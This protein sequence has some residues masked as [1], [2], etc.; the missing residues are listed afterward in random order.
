MFSPE[1]RQRATGL[2][3]FNPK[4]PFETKLFINGE[5]VDSKLGKT[6][7]TV[8]PATEEI[9]THVQEA[10]TQDVDIAVAAAKAAFE[11]GSEWR[12]LPGSGRRDLL[13]KLAQAIEDNSEYLSKLESLDNVKPWKNAAYSA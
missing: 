2:G 13:L 3:A 11:D 1:K 6:F 10:S 8:D 7:P 5:F 4:G 12:Q 9:I